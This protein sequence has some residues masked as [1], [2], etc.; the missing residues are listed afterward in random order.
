MFP[1]R[2]NINYSGSLLINTNINI[3][4]FQRALSIS[5]TYQLFKI[6]PYQFQYQYLLSISTYDIVKLTNFLSMSHFNN[7][8]YWNRLLSIRYQLSILLAFQYWYCHFSL[9]IF[10]HQYFLVHTSNASFI[11]SRTLVFHIA[12]WTI[13]PLIVK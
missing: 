1:Y 4:Y 7:I 3:N 12:I 10:P 11:T 5:I 13:F 2:F 8:N 9:S 6:T